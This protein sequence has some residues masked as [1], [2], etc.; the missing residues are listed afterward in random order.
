MT[1]NSEIAQVRIHFKLQT[2]TIG[3]VKEEKS[4]R[5]EAKR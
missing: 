1:F 2:A 4:A 3:Q 5:Y